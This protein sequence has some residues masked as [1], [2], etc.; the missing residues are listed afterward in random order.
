MPLP[1]ATLSNSVYRHP[2]KGSYARTLRVKYSLLHIHG[3]SLSP[4]HS[5]ASSGSGTSSPHSSFGSLISSSRT[6]RSTQSPPSSRSS[7]A[8]LSTPSN[9]PLPSSRPQPRIQ[10][11]SLLAETRTRFVIN[12]IKK[13]NNV[14]RSKVFRRYHLEII[15][16]PLRTAEFG[17]AYL[18]RVP[19]T[20]PIIA[21]LTV[22][23]PSGNSI[24]P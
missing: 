11:S 7:L 2:K 21:Q 19:L 20:P 17:A 5:Y 24:V 23:D 13:R 18:S 6:S 8:D 10:V 1:V 3:S 9:S 16:H 22:R 4:E 15:Q 12:E 14:E